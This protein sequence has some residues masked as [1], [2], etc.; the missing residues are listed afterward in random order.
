LV[1]FGGAET[2]T[3]YAVLLYRLISFWF[4]LGLGWLLIGE[5]ALEVRR[6]RWGRSAMAAPVEAGPVAYRHHLLRHRHGEDSGPGPRA[7]PAVAGG[8]P[9]QEVAT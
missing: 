9:S 3:A 6:G 7:V 4:I 2:S 5:M 8:P 1:A